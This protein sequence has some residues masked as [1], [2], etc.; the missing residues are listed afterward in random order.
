MSIQRWRSIR[1][2]EDDIEGMDH[3]RNPT[4]EGEDDVD[5]EFAVA[6]VN[7]DDRTRWEEESE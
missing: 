5:E 6:A 1:W 2:L 4:E 7:E 3:A